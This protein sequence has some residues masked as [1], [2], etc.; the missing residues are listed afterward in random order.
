LSGKFFH[1]HLLIF[2]SLTP[3]VYCQGNGSPLRNNRSICKY[4]HSTSRDMRLFSWLLLFI[5][6]PVMGESLL[7]DE[8]P[9]A[10]LGSE[11]YHNVAVAGEGGMSSPE[12]GSI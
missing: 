10:G 11:P 6:D 7:S 3:H 2:Y 12:A 1:D 9:V 5:C 4:V 8:S